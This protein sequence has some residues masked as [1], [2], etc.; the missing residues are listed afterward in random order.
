[1]R[2][3]RAA[4]ALVFAAM[5]LAPASAPAQTVQTL[6]ATLSTT[7]G[8]STGCAATA[9]L[10]VRFPVGTE[11]S[12]QIGG[13]PVGM[14]AQFE[15][16]ADCTNY[17]GLPLVAV[18]S[19]G[20]AAVTSA[21]AVGGWSGVNTVGKCVQVRLSALTSGTASVTITPASGNVTQTTIAAPITVGSTS[22]SLQTLA[23]AVAASTN[24]SWTSSN[25]G[26]PKAVT[27]CLNASAATTFTVTESIDG[28]NFYAATLAG[29]AS[30]TAANY[31]P[32]GAGTLCETISPAAYVKVATSAAVTV[33][34]Q[35]QA[36]Y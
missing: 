26:Y 24:Q 9:V 21:T 22:G 4:L 2:I 36:A 7:C 17:V 30:A 1:M 18:P 23:S 13:S 28:T 35:L 29:S 27:L 32:A 33:T 3:L 8:T 10:P 15:Q 6:N 11:L 14:T 16:S 5:F 34:A 19:T 12:V 25:L 20:T 31:A